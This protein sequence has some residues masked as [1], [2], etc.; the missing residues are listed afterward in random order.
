MTQKLPS[1]KKPC[2]GCS[3][4]MR[5]TADLCGDCTKLRRREF[6]GK[7][8]GWYEP[9]TASGDGKHSPNLFVTLFR[10]EAGKLAQKEHC[11]ACNWE[12]EVP[13]QR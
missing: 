1:G 12:R 3:K 8:T 10:T 2:P 9:C 4:L 6:G 11:T 5:A 13:F 7:R